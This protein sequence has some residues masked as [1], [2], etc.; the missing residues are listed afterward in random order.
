VLRIR[1]KSIFQIGLNRRSIVMP[2]LIAGIHVFRLAVAKVGEGRLGRNNRIA[3]SKFLN[4]PCVS[5][6]HLES[7]LLPG[8]PKIFLQQNRQF[9]ATPRREA[10]Y[11]HRKNPNSLGSN[12]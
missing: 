9:S 2:A 11:G 8:I 6:A 1:V 3:T 12:V 10:S 7:M 4:Q 5:R